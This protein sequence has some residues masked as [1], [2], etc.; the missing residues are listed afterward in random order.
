MALPFT[1]SFPGPGNVYV[2]TVGGKV[3]QANLIISYARDPK[4][5]AVNKLA[6]RTPTSTLSGLFPKLTPDALARIVRNRN[7]AQWA[8][9][10]ERPKGTHNQQDFKFIPYTCNRIADS[11]YVGTQTSQQAAWD[12]DATQTQLLA[13]LMMTRRAD[14]FYSV[15]LDTTN[16]IASHVVTAAVA[17]AFNG[18]TGGFWSAGTVTNKIVQRS[19][20]YMANQIRLS[21][22]DA[23]GYRDLSIVIP[24]E[25]AITLGTSA[26][27]TDQFA[28]S[29]F[30]LAATRLDSEEQNSEWGIPPRLYGMKVVIDGTLKTTSPR[31]SEPGTFVDIMGSTYNTALIMAQPGDLPGNVGQVNSSFS[32]V[33][34]FVYN[35]EEMVTETKADTWNKRLEISIHETYS[36]LM[37]APETAGLITNLFS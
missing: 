32:S 23:V 21:T 17:S 4:K 3:T 16:H 28:R 18:A 5:F 20:M 13:H 22:L 1:T 31:L 8:D 24:P 7:A 37:V 35:G 9:G 11:N 12:I 14:S 6:M 36:F 27:I 15:A 2:P 29:Q 19:L 25:V 26:E 30:A 34:M 33:H 10:Q